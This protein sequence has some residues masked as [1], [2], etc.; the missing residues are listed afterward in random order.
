MRDDR[1]GGREAP[2]QDRE[3]RSRTSRKKEMLELQDLG[4]RLVALPESYLKSCGIPG[5]LVEAVLAAKRIRSFKAL[6]RQIQYIGV[7]MRSVDAGLVVRA[8]DGYTGGR[9]GS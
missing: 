4:A 5:E 6:R 7:I 3:Q 8:L 2:P 9:L 1:D